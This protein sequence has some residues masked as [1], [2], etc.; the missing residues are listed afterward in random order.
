M[1]VKLNGAEV[2]Y[3][4]CINL[5]DDDIREELHIRLAPC[6]EQYFLDA[7]CKAHKNKYGVE[8]TI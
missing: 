7:Y 5:M 4:V 6:A 2:S 1:Y 8:F 3:D